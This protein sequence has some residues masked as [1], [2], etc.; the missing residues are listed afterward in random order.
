[1]SAERVLRLGASLLLSIA[2]A[3]CSGLDRRSTPAP[4][5][6]A[7]ERPKAPV[8]RPAVTP[9]APGTA[10]A[11]TGSLK[12]YPVS[13]PPVAR[14]PV[15]PREP[16][17]PTVVIPPPQAPRKSRPAP[18]PPAPV[19]LPAGTKNPAVL[20]LLKE[21]EQAFDAGDL[22]RS[23]SSVERALRIEPR[24]PFLW[25]RL[26]HIRLTQGRGADAAGLAAKSN[27]FAAGEPS[28]QRDNWMMTATVRR[29]AG[30]LTGAT[31]AERKA[32][33]VQ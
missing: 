11:A 20:S 12:T 18:V 17:G 30:D 6:D 14:P 13:P 5:R 24:N 7:G 4:V 8:T 27:S 2:L 3:G 19:T 32:R 16:S 23:A 1:M 10:P 28:L 31:A 29:S 21:A 25:N 33:S 15:V 26:S 22:S 9:K